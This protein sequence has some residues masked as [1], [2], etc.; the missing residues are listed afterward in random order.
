MPNVAVAQDILLNR[1]II[2]DR[3]NV[4]LSFVFS[5]SK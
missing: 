5:A 4:L 2:C 3:E 1:I